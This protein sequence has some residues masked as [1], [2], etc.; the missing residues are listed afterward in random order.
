MKAI[1]SLL[2]WKSILFII[3]ILVFLGP[4]FSG[5]GPNEMN[6][7][8]T[9]QPPGSG[10][11]L[12]TDHLGR[13]VL[14]RLLEGG[15]VTLITAAIS[16]LL[17]FIIG[18]LYGG[19]SGYFGGMIDSI[20]MRI[21]E[22]LL[23]IPS[24]VVILAFQVLVE[25]SIWSLGVI[26]GITNWLMIA[27]IVRSEF[28]RLKNAEFIQI[29]RMLRTPI[30]E[31]LLQHLL[32]N[33]LPAVFVVT[34]FNFT[35]AIYIEV[36]LSFLGIGIPPAIPSWGSMLYYAQNDILAGAWWIAVFPGIMIFLTVLALN[37]IGE[38]IKDAHGG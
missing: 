37:F 14:T 28:I 1:N 33:S 4:F 17:S 34:L 38:S 5:Y 13:D 27:R 18:V 29:A 22:A 31:I 10:H 7:E 36:S 8:N 20:L 2:I 16:V 15:K 21:L 23:V 25:G 6:L 35:S 26:I 19:I 3:I 11:F 32:R 30:R 9:Y 12:G 24:L